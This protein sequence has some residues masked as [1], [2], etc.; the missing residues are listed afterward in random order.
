MLYNSEIPQLI[1]LTKIDKVCDSVDEDT[2]YVFKSKKVEE[3]I[4]KASALLGL[5]RGDILPMKNYEKEAELD[6]SINILTLLSL[7]QILHYAED[8]LIQL[9]DKMDDEAAQNEV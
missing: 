2:A 3:H 8:F 9:K 6:E 1:L 5:P 4:E 7:R